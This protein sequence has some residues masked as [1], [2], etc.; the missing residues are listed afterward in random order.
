MV[1]FS[2]LRDRMY[3]GCFHKLIVVLSVSFFVLFF[4]SLHFDLQKEHAIDFAQQ[5]KRKEEGR[6]KQRKRQEDGR[7]IVKKA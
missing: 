1:M 2:I 7:V 5:K 6:E 4:S 3:A